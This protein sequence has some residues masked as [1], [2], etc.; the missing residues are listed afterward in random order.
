MRCLTRLRTAEVRK[1]NVQ[2]A[3]WATYVSLCIIFI[4]LNCKRM[5][6]HVLLQTPSPIL[7]YI[8]SRDY[9]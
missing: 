5:V 7:L 9:I 6:F 8:N 3:I 4:Y 2:I 1:H